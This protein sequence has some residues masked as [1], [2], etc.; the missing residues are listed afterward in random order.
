L[1]VAAYFHKWRNVK[2]KIQKVVSTLL[3]FTLAAAVLSANFVF[4]APVRAAEDEVVLWQSMASSASSKGP[5]THGNVPGLSYSRVAVSDP[6]V[7]STHGWEVT[8]DD[9]QLFLDWGAWFYLYDDGNSSVDLTAYADK[10]L[11]L[12]FAVMMSP[13]KGAMEFNARMLSSGNWVATGD[14]MFTVANEGWQIVEIPISDFPKGGFDSQFYAV[15]VLGNWGGP[16]ADGD[17]MIFADIKLSYRDGGA[18]DPAD[19]GETPDPT[20]PGGTPDPPD[21]T[22]PDKPTGPVTIGPVAI[23]E[24]TVTNKPPESWGAAGLIHQAVSVNDPAVSSTRAWETTFESVAGFLDPTVN[25]QYYIF[26]DPAQAVDMTPFLSEG[27]MLSYAMRISGSGTF[28]F[29]VA[30][31]STNNGWMGF[32]TKDVTIEK[33]SWQRVEIPYDTMNVEDAFNPD[34]FDFVWFRPV[35]GDLN[36]GDTILLADLKATYEGEIEV[37]DSWWEYDN[38]YTANAEELWLHGSSDSANATGPVSLELTGD[39]GGDR[40]SF[41]RRVTATGSGNWSLLMGGKQLDLLDEAYIFEKIALR[42]Y[43][44]SE[45]ANLRLAV[46]FEDA[47][48]NAATTDVVVPAAGEWHEIQIRTDRLSFSGFDRTKVTGVVVKSADSNGDHNDVALFIAGAAIYSNSPPRLASD[49]V[50]TTT[51]AAAFHSNPLQIHINDSGKFTALPDTVNLVNARNTWRVMMNRESN[52]GFSVGLPLP[53]SID[54]TKYAPF[55]F[56]S[57]AT[58]ASNYTSMEIVFSDGS[59]FYAQEAPGGTEWSEYRVYMHDIAKAGVDVSK[60]QEILIRRTRTIGE[61]IAINFSE[62]TMVSDTKDLAYSFAG[63]SGN[64]G[65]E[66]PEDGQD[67]ENGLDGKINPWILI[68]MAAG[69]VI[70]IASV[71]IVI[72]LKRKGKSKQ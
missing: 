53:D 11:K 4:P 40:F 19:P 51:I 3:A 13:H 1:A 20:D 35:G 63:G 49:N 48:G 65:G 18:T 6:L 66:G 58:A 30:M 54:F 39:T 7:N 62:L 33:G 9:A 47:D 17:K 36:D 10:D 70:V 57:F 38:P 56:F 2:M 28:T 61:G 23:W 14:A 52:D 21:P 68:A 31:G 46:G 5:E 27:L 42:L 34:A 37:I 59:N 26:N 8:F 72:I 55:G 50:L 69:A 67:K 12:S 45:K 41:A 32:A 16:L 24:N 71:I 15:A 29:N 43:I 60:I 25:S 22:T 64:G 44:K